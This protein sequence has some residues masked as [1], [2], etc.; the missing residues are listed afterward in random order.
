M[1][2]II[3]NGD[4]EANWKQWDWEAIFVLIIQHP[5]IYSYRI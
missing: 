4:G 5:Q 3:G 2:F 1:Q